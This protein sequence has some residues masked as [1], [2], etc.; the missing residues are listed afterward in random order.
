M[1]D[2]KEQTTHAT[3]CTQFITDDEFV[4]LAH[5]MSQTIYDTLHKETPMKAIPEGAADAES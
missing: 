4:K 5:Q 1:A 3:F 2:Q